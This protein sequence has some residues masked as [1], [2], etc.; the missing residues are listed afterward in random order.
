VLDLT[1]E[2]G[3]PLR[4]PRTGYTVSEELPDSFVAGG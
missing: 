1:P 4:H 2:I 3:L